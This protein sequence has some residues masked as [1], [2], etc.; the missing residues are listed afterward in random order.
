[1]RDVLI[2]ILKLELPASIFRNN[3]EAMDEPW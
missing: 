1:M 3:I 2:L